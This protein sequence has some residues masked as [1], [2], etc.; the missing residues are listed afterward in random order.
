MYRKSSAFLLLMALCFTARCALAE[1]RIRTLMDANWHLYIGDLTHS[2]GMPVAQWNWE[3]AQLQAPPAALP[4]NLIPFTN[5][6]HAMPGADTFHGQTGFHWYYT[7]LPNLP[8]PHRSLHFQWVDD[9]ADVY[10]NGV[11]LLHHE[12]WNT[13]FNVTVDKQWHS[14]SPNVLVVL[15]QNTA[16]A[17]GIGPVFL[18]NKNLQAAAGPAAEHYNTRYWRTVHL[19]DDFVVKGKFTPTADVSHGSLPVGIAWYRHRFYVPASYRGR[20][21]WVN[22]EGIYRDSTTWIN[23]HRLGTHQ[24]GYIG[25]RYN[26][27]KWLHY[28]A[29]NTIAVRVN[30]TAPEGWWYEGGGIYRHVWLVAASPVHV[31]PDGLFVYSEVH[32]NHSATLPIQIRLL[33]QTSHAQPCSVVFT[34]L[35]PANVKLMHTAVQGMLGTNGMRMHANIQ[36]AHPVLW[37][38]HHP[39]L[40]ILRA[41]IYVHGRLQDNVQTALGIRTIHFDPSRGFFLNGKH[42]ELQGT[43]NHQDFAGVGIGM[44]DSILWWRIERLKQMGCNAYRCSHNP[45]APE[46]LD[47]CDHLGMLVMDEN[48]HLGDCYTPKTPRGTGYSKL[49]D[50]KAMVRRDR[51]HPSIIMWSMCNEE[52]LQGSAEGARIFAA[53]RTATL[54]LDPTRPITCAMNGDWGRGI[55]NVEDLQGCNYNPNAY[56][57]FHRQFPNKPMYASEMGSTVSTRGEYE[58]NPEKG[59]VSAY[60]VN[61]PPWAQTAEVTWSS[62]AKH[63]FMAGGFVWTGFDY[64]GEPTPYGW[65]CVNSHFGLIDEAGFF[66]DDAYY[67]KAWWTH[68]PMVHLLPPWTWPGREGSSIAVWCYSNCAKIALYLN[69]KKLGE[70]AMP[71]YGHVQWNVPY[72]PGTLEAIGYNEDGRETAKEIEQTTGKPARIRLT[73]IWKHLTANGEDTAVINAAIIDSKGRIVPYASSMVTFKVTGPARVCGVGN[74]D[75]SCHEPDRAHQRSAFHGLCMADLQ[76]ESKTGTVTI[77]AVSPGLASGTLSLPIRR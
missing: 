7:V 21:V 58:N 13:S 51:N 36:I 31:A 54:K 16:G 53:M 1:Q 12:G 30:A 4:D 2:L 55:S 47:A 50:L 25:V 40:Y 42:V 61:A 11:H 49:T 14:H 71:L 72:Q 76:A 35:S 26:L 8:A 29:D 24:S 68:K 64:K 45:P 22:F 56:T 33:N 6:Q 52:P 66:K 44:P 23:G 77:T 19:P 60:D 69:G 70:K 28:G 46:L 74:G 67:Y 57:A 34:L 32:K 15:V 17:G 18:Q 75:P 37:S 39:A 38:L 48:R 59:Y 5:A 41:S 73:T 65:P 3:P 10:L 9:N 27:S 43:C 62:I 63:P 20:S